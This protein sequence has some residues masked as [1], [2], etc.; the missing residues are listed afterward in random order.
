MKWFHCPLEATS[1]T[2]DGSHFYAP[3]NAES[4]PR[5][6][7][8]FLSIS[9]MESGVMWLV[10]RWVICNYIHFLYH[11]TSLLACW[12]IRKSYMEKLCKGM[13]H[14]IFILNTAAKSTNWTLFVKYSLICIRS[15]Q[16]SISILQIY[17]TVPSHQKN[18]HISASTIKLL[19]SRS[20]VC[21]LQI[22]PP[23]NQPT[24]TNTI[25]TNMVIA[26]RKKILTFQYPAT[27]YSPKG[28]DATNATFPRQLTLPLLYNQPS[29]SEQHAQ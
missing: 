15:N 9:M 19:S 7:H 5:V 6:N 20:I 10:N 8:R 23:R 4:M 25:H 21:F 28:M 24:I 2:R 26:T 29:I 14:C 12:Q 3:L 17:S 18:T 1:G 22:S 16:N 13:N 27:Q 11:F